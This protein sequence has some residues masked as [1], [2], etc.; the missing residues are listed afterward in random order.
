M[1]FQPI[2]EKNDKDKSEGITKKPAVPDG[3]LRLIEAMQMGPPPE[4]EI[5]DMKNHKF[6]STQPVPAYDD[7]TTVDG[8]IKMI[9]R[10]KVSKN[11]PPLLDGF[12]W[13]TMD[14]EDDKQL[15]EIYTLLEGH[16]VEDKDQ[17]F[18][19][20]YSRDFLSW[21]VCCRILTLAANS[22]TD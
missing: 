4:E 9:N 11:A 18:R 7:T 20:K 22:L 15:D 2:Q 19:F 16:Y 3:L 21:Y 8:P 17:R 12:E 5:K 14:L 13:V 6:W 10:D 1:L